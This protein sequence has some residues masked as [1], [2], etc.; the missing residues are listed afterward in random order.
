MKYTI[1]EYFAKLGEQFCYF[2]R[3][4]LIPAVLVHLIIEG[5][6]RKSFTA[7]FVYMFTSPL[8]FLYNTL[9]ICTTLSV[10]FLF[11][12]RF[13]MRFLVC[14]LWLT[15]GITDFV[16]LCF[17]VT[18]FTAA[19]LRLL[20][21]AFAIMDK[22][23]SPVQIVLIGVGILL[24][25]VA[26]VVLFFRSQKKTRGV[27]FFSGLGLLGSFILTCFLF[28]RL[29]VAVGVL[30][31]TFGNLTQGFY[32][33]GLPYCFFSSIFNTGISRPSGYSEDEVNRIGSVT[34]DSPFASPIPTKAPTPTAASE[35][36]PI[37][38][39]PFAQPTG[40]PSLEPSHGPQPTVSPTATPIPSVTV[41]PTPSVTKTPP[42]DTD[43]K[44]PNIIFLQLESFFD[45]NRIKG[46]SFSTN[47][48]PT[49]T[50]LRKEFPS[51]FLNVPSV[52][53][54]TANT[55]FEILTGMNLDFFGP[56][57][58]PY[59]TILQ[60]TPCESMAFNLSAVGLIP[61]A[62]HN[63]D[64]D[65]YDRHIVFSQLGFQTFTPIE[66]MND[67]EINPLGWPKD[68]ILIQEIQK[69]LDSTEGN[70]FI[71]TISVQ[72]HGAYP[73]YEVIKD[74]QVVIQNL[75]EELENS[76]YGLSYYVNQIYE[77]DLFVSDLIDMLS[78][79]EE[80]VVLVM[81]GDHL[82]TFPFTEEMM[83]NDSLFQT[84]YIIWDNQRNFVPVRKTLEAYELSAY[85]LNSFDIHE[86]LFTRFHQTQGLSTT[87]LTDLEILEYDVLYGDMESYGGVS[88]YTSTDLQFG[89]RP[90]RISDVALKPSPA[91]KLRV[92]IRGE[93]FTPFS[94][95]IIDNQIY[96]TS[97]LN[98]GLLML[99]EFVR[100]EDDSFDVS[101]AQI[102]VDN[103]EFSQ[104]PITHVTVSDSLYIDDL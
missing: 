42:V 50:K 16:L 95:I 19:D 11:R 91:G 26:A 79:R 7:P 33:N 80:E 32:D 69:T 23:L 65:F 100:P 27:S 15:I 52:G 83:D 4:C 53:A 18:P 54:G 70:D 96:N 29:F 72:G 17:R 9:L 22:Y 84:E 25:I 5:L 92:Y 76:Y 36:P 61:H 87:Y 62:I 67:Y 35:V 44:V 63:N 47:P 49:Y 57:E 39:T 3:E 37:A 90:I 104:T 89:T 94:T 31:R 97:Y 56:G 48:V 20:D 103:Y 86:G 8:V 30:D 77:M 2:T 24:V 43:G 71:Y 10:S 73:D 12:R 99:N 21:S 101:V 28:T 88:P 74:P 46:A 1:R 34:K 82:P 40:T 78:E 55:E 98:S 60:T 66:Y 6:S 102:G 38:V 14:T 68:N 13:F 93:N 45:P 64:G 58:Y 85:V 51:G 81:Y 59:K 75:P 41:S